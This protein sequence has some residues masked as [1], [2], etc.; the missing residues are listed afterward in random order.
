M[1]RYPQSTAIAATL[2]RLLRRHGIQVT[3]SDIPWRPGPRLSVKR[4]GVLC[5]GAWI[6]LSGDASMERADAEAER[7]RILKV[8]EGTGRYA[9]DAPESVQGDM[10]GWGW[11]MHAEPLSE[12]HAPAHPGQWTC[13]ARL[14]SEA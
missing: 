13:F 6:E 1:I 14:R 11:R 10:G 7:R 2:S 8:L 3:Y 9:V 4:S 12:I 5:P